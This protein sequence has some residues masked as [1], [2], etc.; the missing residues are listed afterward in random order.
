M[1]GIVG[2][3]GTRQASPILLEG[4]KRLEYRGYDSAGIATVL[5]GK[6]EQAKEKGKVSMLSRHIKSQGLK[7][8]TGIGHTRWATHG[9]PN[10]LNAHP[11]I[12]GDTIAIVHNGIIENFKELKD[13]LLKKGCN[14]KSQTDSEVIAWLIYD[15]YKNT[16]DLLKSVQESVSKLEGTFGILII[17]KDLPDTIIAVRRGSPLLL[18]IAQDQLFIGSDATAIVSYTKQIVYLEDDEIAVCTGGNYQILD[19]EN[20]TKKRETETLEM[21]AATIQKEGYDHFLIKEIM[22]QPRVITDAIRGRLNP[23]EGSAH[24]GGLNLS[25]QQLNGFDRILTIGCG[26]AYYAGL[27][28]KYMIER[29]AKVHVDVEFASEFRYREPVL[30]RHTL[31]IIISQSGETADSLASLKELKRKNIFTLGI[32]NAVGSTIAREVDGGTYLHAGPEI[33]VASTKAFTAQVVTQMILALQLAR[34]R[35]MGVTDGEQIVKAISELPG[36]IQQVLDTHQDIEIIAKSVA[37]CNNAFY[38]G[39]DL[40]Y[41]VALEG[42]LKLKEISYI[43]AEAYPAGEM[44]HGAIALIDDDFLTVFLVPQNNTYQKV[45]SNLEETKARGGQVVIVA[46][47]GD[48]T[49]E[50]YSKNIIKIPD[51][52]EVVQPILVTVALQL[53][54]YYVAVARGTD[55]DQPRNLAKSVTVE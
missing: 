14:F 16:K 48:K 10:E 26:S 47:T 15:S 7:G 34:S 4:L 1:C 35:D 33:S 54:A 32:I 12:A 31:G 37:N 23:E 30:D 5:N 28:G 46:T 45:I 20:N 49:V 24:L 2:Y 27:L 53:F 13:D 29:I 55:V 17:C 21:E 40:L 44:K 41:P 50:K 43:H 22:E 42:S 11:H 19:F 36:L 52:Q 9:E 51:C 38:L 18:G 8:N 6:I 25:V 3:A 39:R